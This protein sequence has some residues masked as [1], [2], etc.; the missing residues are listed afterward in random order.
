MMSLGTSPL[1]AT[2]S[3][4]TAIPARAAGDPGAT[5]TTRGLDT[6]F[7]DT[8]HARE[9]GLR[10]VGGGGFRAGWLPSH[11][12]RPHAHRADSRRRAAGHG[13]TRLGRPRALP[14]RA[15][16]PEPS[17]L[18][19]ASHPQ[20]LSLGEQIAAIGSGDLDPAELLDS[21]L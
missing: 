19:A 16:R 4:P 12:R 8:V 14:P 15:G 1:M 7:N 20:D 2:I 18:M 17:P 9:R 21:T 3:S 6:A 5:A 11:G 13:R 10:G